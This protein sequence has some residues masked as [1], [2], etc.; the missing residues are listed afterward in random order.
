MA[1]Q[2][3]IFI[4]IPK[5]GGQTLRK[6]VEQNYLQK[7]VFRCY[8]T[9]Q[10][11]RNLEDL[12]NLSEK[13]QE[14]IKVFIGH[15]N[16]GVHKH[17]IEVDKKSE[18][19]YIT[20]M[21]EPI[22]RVI[23]AYQH[24]MRTNNKL[25]KNFASIL[26][27]YEKKRILLDNFQTRMI[28]GINPDYGER[29]SGTRYL[30]ALIQ[31]NF[32]VELVIA[33]TPKEY[34]N[35]IRECEAEIDSYF[36]TNFNSSL[37]WKHQL[38]PSVD[39]LKGIELPDIFFLTI[40]KNPYSWLLSMYKRPYQSYKGTKTTFYEFIRSPWKTVKRENAPEE[41]ANPVILWNQKNWSYLNLSKYSNAF[42]IRYE[43]LLELPLEI[44]YKIQEKTKIPMKVK[45]RVKQVRNSTKSKKKK[46]DDYF[47]YYIKNQSWQELLNQKDID[48]INNNLDFELME[49][50]GYEK[51]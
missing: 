9:N 40:S 19:N 42:H 44:L 48:F 8:P 50:L 30:R 51:I 18:V 7:E 12:K 37:G 49:S 27:V 2:T 1:K 5:T 38:A 33:K 32:N 24:L 17:I 13:E 26:K 16:Y 31:K 36:Y 46:Y 15:M 14:Q 11:Y 45:D 35:R 47:D 29:N 25:R 3:T 23:S 22:D 21:R 28:S 41:F 10:K 43:N 34:S 6:V 20:M 4:H 39:Q